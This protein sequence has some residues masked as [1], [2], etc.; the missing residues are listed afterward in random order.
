VFFIVVET[1]RSDAL[2]PESA[3]F[4]C[5]WR[6]DE[7]M[8]LGETFAA[9]NA[10][11][12]SWFS[13]FSGRFPI[14]WERGRQAG[15]LAFLPAAIK[16]AGYHIEARLAADYHYMDMVRTCFGE[17]HELAVLENLDEGSRERIFPTPERETRLLDRVKR[18][19]AERPAGG[20]MH[21]IALDSPHYPYKWAAKFDPP[22]GDYEENP[23]FPLR[24]SADEVRLIVN[25]YW[26][27]VAWIDHLIGGFA[28]W[29]KQ[30]GR[31]DSALIIV[32]GD[33]GEEFKEQGSWFHC[34]ALN[35][36]QTRVPILIKL[37][38]GMGRGPAAEAAS[39][40]DIPPTVLD[41]LGFDP[42]GWAGLPGI[43][44]LR[45]EK[46]TIALGTHYAGKTGEAMLL[47]RDG[48][49]ASFGW[50]NYWEPR[51]PDVIWLE[52]IQSPGGP[53]ND[54]APA[55]C[56]PLLREK[57]PDAF[58]RVLEKAAAR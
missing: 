14:H 2:R 3:P 32:T 5:R 44:L 7:C 34:S 23:L 6:D 52:R 4:L 18:S 38:S 49:Q 24:P 17:P 57:F 58:G 31:Y 33:H 29:L 46:R 53:L 47:V 37:P 25:R 26:N 45:P 27:S 15:R 35:P 54:L 43:S 55:R 16:S 51:A 48:W 10:T 11:H 13:M 22:L 41:V 1:L 30:Q 19:V 56:L 42:A 8:R 39:H 50:R 21:I 28:D 9:S 36:Q 20:S 12:L 40:L